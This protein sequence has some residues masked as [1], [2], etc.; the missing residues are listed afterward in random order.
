[1]DASR[2]SLLTLFYAWL[3]ATLLS[4]IPSTLYAAATGGDVAEATRA[5]GAMLISASASPAELFAAAALVHSAVSLYW[6]TI[7][8]LAL[9][10]RHTALWAVAAAAAIGLVDLRVIAPFFFPEVAALAFWPQM[11]DHLMWG[12][13]LGVVLQVRWRRAAGA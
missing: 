4:G 5:A 9:P 3:A 1:L 7:L 10:R 12:A 2:H 6:A 8:W 11:A 13:S